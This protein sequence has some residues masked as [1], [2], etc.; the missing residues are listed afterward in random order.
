MHTCLF[1][2]WQ[3]ALEPTILIWCICWSLKHKFEK[4]TFLLQ[5]EALKAHASSCASTSVCNL[6]APSSPGNPQNISNRY[7]S[8]SVRPRRKTV[9]GSYI[10]VE[11]NRYKRMNA[12]RRSD[13][14]H[15]FIIFSIDTIALVN[16]TPDYQLLSHKVLITCFQCLHR[17]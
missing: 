2:V 3:G 1:H 9:H 5:P 15:G 7:R 17:S 11:Y 4:Y 12:A 16:L 13:S 14:S 6:S 8:K 10:Y